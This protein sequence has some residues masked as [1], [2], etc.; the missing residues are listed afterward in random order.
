MTTRFIM[1]TLI[2]VISM[3]FLPLSHRRFSSRNVSS[4]EERGETAVQ[5][6]FAGYPSARLATEHWLFNRPLIAGTQILIHNWD[7]EQGFQRSY[8]AIRLNQKFRFVCC[9]D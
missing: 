2:Y 5:A 7:P 1:L 9:A 8:A 6:V 3:E 4:G